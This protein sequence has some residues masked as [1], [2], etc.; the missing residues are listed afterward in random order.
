[1]LPH[2][3]EPHET[4]VA[5]GTSAN[6]DPFFPQNVL[7]ICDWL[8]ASSVINSA[9]WLRGMVQ[10]HECIVFRPARIVVEKIG[11][12]RVRF[13]PNLQ[14]VTQQRS[15]NYSNSSHAMRSKANLRGVVWY[16]VQKLENYRRNLRR[17]IAIA[18]LIDLDWRA[19]AG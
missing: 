6:C 4:S 17:R 10:T 2:S 14:D 7:P 11:K 13:N 18:A 12:V 15:V 3:V 5:F 9:K 19:A 8:K 1:M 16:A